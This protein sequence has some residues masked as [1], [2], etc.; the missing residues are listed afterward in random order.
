MDSP[1]PAN[2]GV[3]PARIP[4]VP[5]VTADIRHPARLRMDGMETNLALL[6]RGP[7]RSR[8]PQDLVATAAFAAGGLLLVWSAHIHFHLWG[9]ANGYRSIP[10]I[11][12]LFLLQSFAGL[13]IGVGVIAVRRL[14]AAVVGIGFSLL[15]VA[16]F[17]V[18]VARGLFG[19]QDSWL[20]PFAKVAF[21]VE[22]AAAAVL[23]LA[24]GLC[25]VGS[26]PDARPGSTPAG[27]TS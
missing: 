10:T 8:R 22:V 14:W 2:P 6:L 16:G 23:M 12:S 5:A 26:V 4:A 25:L 7:G 17:L 15:T 3:V 19:F 1:L 9:G 11:G 20:A 13:V 21:T 24:A 18:S 27:T